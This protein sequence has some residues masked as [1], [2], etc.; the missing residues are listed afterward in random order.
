MD[1]VLSHGP[2]AVIN[3]LLMSQIELRATHKRFSLLLQMLAAKE[4]LDLHG[5]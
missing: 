1:Q 2:G 5:F 3:I 4:E